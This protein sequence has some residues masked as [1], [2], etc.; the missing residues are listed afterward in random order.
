MKYSTLITQAREALKHAYVPYSHFS[1][2]AALITTD[3][4]VF[5]GCNVENVSY[6]ASICAERVALV[7]AISSG[8]RDFEAIAIAC[9]S[10]Q[11]ILPCGI[12]RQML[13]EFNPNLIVVATTPTETQTFILKDLLPH[14]FDSFQGS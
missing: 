7:K 6:G 11:L 12:C 5:T 4:T 14:A 1:V 8:K 2:G 10:T 13:A 3:G 9:S